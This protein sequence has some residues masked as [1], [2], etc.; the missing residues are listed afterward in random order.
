MWGCAYKSN[1]FLLYA[2]TPITPPQLWDAVCVC[3][4]VCVCVYQSLL[5]NGLV[6]SINDSETFE[7]NCNRQMLGEYLGLNKINK[8]IQKKIISH[9]PSEGKC[10]LRMPKKKTGFRA[11]KKRKLS[12]TFLF[13][14]FYWTD[15]FSWLGKKV[16]HH[17]V[18]IDLKNK[19]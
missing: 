8:Q 1:I 3:V 7:L 10:D 18:V 16:L 2:Q 14:P 19:S 12:A 6:K 13:T 15:S 5:H 11:P 4:C 17:E 9:Q